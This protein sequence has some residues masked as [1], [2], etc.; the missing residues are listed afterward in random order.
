MPFPPQRR[1]PSLTKQTRTNPNTAEPPDQIGT[2]HGSPPN[3]PKKTD[4][5]SAVA[6][7]RRPSPHLTSPLE[8][9][10]DEFLGRGWSSRL[11]AGGM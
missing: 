4:L 11:G 7:S 6:G 10:R 8:G 9:G 1:R 2:P 5:N 3:T